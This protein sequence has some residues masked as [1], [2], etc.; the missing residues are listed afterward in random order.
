MIPEPDLLVKG[1]HYYADDIAWIFLNNTVDLLLWTQERSR[2]DKFLA[3]AS[4]RLLEL[5]HCLKEFKLG[6]SP[7]PRENISSYIL[8]TFE[9]I[10]RECADHSGSEMRGTVCLGKR[11]RSILVFILT[12]PKTANQIILL[13]RLNL[14]FTKEQRFTC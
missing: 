5:R 3:F 6:F 4:K 8:A 11:A 7:I 12:T 2:G 9:E 10:E 1:E 14:N 13:C